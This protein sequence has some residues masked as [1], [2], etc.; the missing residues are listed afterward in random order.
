MK[1]LFLRVSF[2]CLTAGVGILF[3]TM[4]IH[5][6]A[7]YTYGRPGLP[8]G[9]IAFH[10]Q[11]DGRSKR[12]IF[13]GEI[14]PGHLTLEA[15]LDQETVKA[16]TTFKM[17]TYRCGQPTG[18]ADIRR[19]EEWQYWEISREGLFQKTGSLKWRLF[20]WGSLGGAKAADYLG[21]LGESEFA[22]VFG[23]ERGCNDAGPP[24]SAV[25]LWS[26]PFCLILGCMLL[27]AVAAATGTLLPPVHRE[28]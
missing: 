11:P 3:G 27:S 12:N 15:L 14:G 5:L 7:E 10:K 16:P 26:S 24:T 22:S 28:R 2:V 18:A 19:R 25:H 21:D 1:P 6:L 17:R 23:P 9:S 13:I 20:T 8:E 4:L